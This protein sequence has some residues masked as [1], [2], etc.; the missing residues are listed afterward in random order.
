[1]DRFSEKQR[2][3]VM[4]RVRSRDTKPE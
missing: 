3:Y 2:S 1:M 4:S